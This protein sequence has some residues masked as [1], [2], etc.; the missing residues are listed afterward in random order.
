MHLSCRQLVSSKHTCFLVTGDKGFYWAM[1]EVVALHNS[2]DGCNANTVVRAQCGAACV[3]PTIFD[4]SF[5]RIGFKVMRAVRSL[6]RHH[7]HV[8]LE[9][10]SLTIF[11][12]FSG[13]F[14]HYYVPSGVNKSFYAYLL[15]EVEQEL[16]YFFRVSRRTWN[17]CQCIKIAPQG[18]RF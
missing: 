17:L 12:T 15:S 4:I 3:Y 2:H 6:L 14:A 8:C 1:F 13:R 7:V 18:C 9:H 16:L 10:H 5:N 11:I